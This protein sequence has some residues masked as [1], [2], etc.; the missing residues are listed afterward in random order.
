MSPESLSLSLM[1][2]NKMAKSSC[3]FVICLSVQTC[4]PNQ[5]T[6]AGGTVSQ[7]SSTRGGLTDGKMLYA[8]GLYLPLPFTV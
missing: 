5:I 2:L 8:L 4:L 6:A 1:E 7:P 3:K